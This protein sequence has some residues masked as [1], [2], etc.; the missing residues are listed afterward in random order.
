MFFYTYSQIE[1]YDRNCWQRKRDWSGYAYEQV[2]FHHI[3]QIKQALGISGVYCH[4][5]SWRSKNTQNGA[6]VDLV[7]DRRDQI[8]NLCEVKFSINPYAI[9]KKYAEELRNKIGTFTTE[10]GTRKSV[11]L[12]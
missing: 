6:Q 11:F 2:C 9:T 7:I 10:T 1:Y 3:Q 4:I 12:P 5:S 8:I